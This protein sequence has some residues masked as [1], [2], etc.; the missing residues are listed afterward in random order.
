[1]VCEKKENHIKIARV[2]QRWRH[3]KTFSLPGPSFP[4]QNT[5][6]LAKK[7]QRFGLAPRLRVV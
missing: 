4:Y 5:R 1:V 7:I 2:W 3:L 6:F